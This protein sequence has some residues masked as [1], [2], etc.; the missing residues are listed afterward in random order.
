MFP[1]RNNNG[2]VVAHIIEDGPDREINCLALC[3][4]CEKS[5][6]K[7]LKPLIYNAITK[8][9]NCE[10][11]ERWKDLGDPILSTQLK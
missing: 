3:P 9:N 4:N 8:I 7:V 2:L 1:G 11:P 6:D 10:I 5:F